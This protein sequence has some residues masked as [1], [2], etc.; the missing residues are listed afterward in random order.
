MPLPSRITELV[1]NLHSVQGQLETAI[2]EE[3]AKIAEK[4]N[5]DSVLIGAYGN[6]YERN[7]KEVKCKPID[8]LDTV[9][10]DELHAGGFQA[11]WTKDKGWH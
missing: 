11:Y 6:T 2:M 4:R 8:D 3:M 7:G 1:G 9:Y 5:L 10:L